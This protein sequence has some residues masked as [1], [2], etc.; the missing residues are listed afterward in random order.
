MNVMPPQTFT[1]SLESQRSM[2]RSDVTARQFSDG[3]A[4]RASYRGARSKSTLTACVWG[5]RSAAGGKQRR[6]D[7]QNLGTDIG[8][9]LA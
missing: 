8:A 7:T 6:A 3:G 1:L 5:L 4:Q 2:F 9:S